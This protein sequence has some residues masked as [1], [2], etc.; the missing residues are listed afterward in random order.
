MVLSRSRVVDSARTLGSR[1]VNS[2]SYSYL[3]FLLA[4]C[5]S[6]PPSVTPAATD[7]SPDLAR[8]IADAGRRP[9][10]AALP[11]LTFARAERTADS[12]R[13][14]L[15]RLD[16]IP[17]AGLAHEEKLSLELLKWQ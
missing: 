6:A 1:G 15:R 12:A 13:A 8:L 14:M 3:L 16:A 17:T 11:D 4:A 2:H 9:P 7:A 10:A 5:H